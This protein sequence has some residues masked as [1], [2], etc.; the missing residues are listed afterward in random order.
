MNFI[1]RMI[2]TSIV[3]FGLSYILRGVHLDTFT[4]AIVLAFVLAILN[5]IVKPILIFITFPITLVTLGLFLF[6][7]NAL[8]IILADKLLK[9]FAVDGFWW[10]LLFSL[11]LSIVTSVLYKEKRNEKE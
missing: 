9:G 10:A 6:V 7:I 1:M 2:V 3:A 8:I 4:T 5:A 11:L